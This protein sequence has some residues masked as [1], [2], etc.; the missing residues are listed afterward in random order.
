MTNLMIRAQLEAS[1]ASQRRLLMH[2]KPRFLHDP[3]D[4]RIRRFGMKMLKEWAA[5]LHRLSLPDVAEQTKPRKRRKLKL[6]KR[7]IV[8]A[9]ADFVASNAA[10]RISARELLAE[11]AKS[12][13]SDFDVLDKFM[14]PP[15]GTETALPRVQDEAKDNEAQS[16]GEDQQPK[17]EGQK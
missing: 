10:P 9:A 5:L 12:Q 3:R 17:N 13:G 15:G 11:H 14:S 2:Y 4:E 1:T 7:E 16:A 8:A 6:T